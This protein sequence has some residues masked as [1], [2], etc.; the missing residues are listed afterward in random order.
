MTVQDDGVLPPYIARGGDL[1][2]AQP[3]RLERCTMYSFLFGAD[4][5]ALVRMLDAQLN[6]VSAPAGTIYKPLLPMAT[7]VCADVV[8]SYSR[9]PPDAEKGWMAERDFGIWIPVVAG[10][11]QG[12]GFKPARIGW[13][14]PYVFVDNVAAMVTGREVFGFWKQTATLTLPPSPQDPGPFTV[15]AL[16]IERFD[17]ASEAATMR[18]VE[19]TSREAS[20]AGQPSAWS[21]PGEALL[22]LAGDLKRLFFDGVHDAEALP[23]SAWEMIKL[24]MEEAVHGDVPLVFL[25]QL[26]DVTDPTR[27]CYQAVVEAP[28][29]MTKWYGGGLCH[30]H[31]LAFAPC[32]SHPIARDL[33]LPG[34]GATSELGFWTL[35]DFDMQAGRTIAE[36][37]R[38]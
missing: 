34:P 31:D 23:I 9:T 19:A 7:F 25:R 38:G 37:G 32:D 18:L 35:I 4:Y 15:D 6:A 22:H 26:R 8:K 12:G 20:G 14:L 2:M 30:P 16:A 13:Y 3:L 1:T 29:Q 33:G 28:A 11:N 27:A 36:R 24:L 21:S 5:R 10:S 17:P